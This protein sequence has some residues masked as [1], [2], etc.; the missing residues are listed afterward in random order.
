MPA[1]GQAETSS[2]GR[3]RLIIHREK[4]GAADG[5][6][7]LLLLLLLKVAESINGGKETA[8]VVS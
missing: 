3:G 4:T 1:Y 5:L 2:R 7:G 8:W 6:L